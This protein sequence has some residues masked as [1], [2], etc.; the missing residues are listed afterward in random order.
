MPR[1]QIMK[2]CDGMDS[3]QSEVAVQFSRHAYLMKESTSK[4]YSYNS[5]GGI[6]FGLQ[7]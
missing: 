6:L 1:K 4:V 2:L 5:P 7:N 3:M